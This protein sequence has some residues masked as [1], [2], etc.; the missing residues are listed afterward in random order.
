MDRA[1]IL[2]R[3]EETLAAWNRGDPEG[4]VAIMVEDVIWHDV[5]LP[6]PLH[7]REALKQ[8]AHGYMSAFPDL[9][10]QTTSD[11]FQ[12]PRLAQEWT[13]TG[14]H[15][16]YLMGIA[17]TGRAMKTYGATVITFDE[18]GQAIEGAM[19]W[20]VTALMHQL[21]LLTEPHVTDTTAGKSAA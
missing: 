21:G 13:A 18:D 6:M 11:T 3:A 1:L 12:A 7:G 17:P 14:T 8:A 5:A 19:Y 4:V 2:K 16:G 10:I 15:R 20:N 9:H